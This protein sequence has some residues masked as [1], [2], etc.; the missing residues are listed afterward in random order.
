MTEQPIKSKSFTTLNGQLNTN[1][2]GD[3]LL[4]STKQ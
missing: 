3:V 2:G 1:P 4:K